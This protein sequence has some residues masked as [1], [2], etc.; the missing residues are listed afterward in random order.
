MKASL[1]N[2]RQSPRKVRLV[3]KSVKG[4]KVAEALAILNFMPKRAAEPLMKLISSAVANSGLKI[5]DLIVKNIEVNKG[6]VLK[7]MMPRARG[8]GFGINKRTSHV[9]VTLESKNKPAEVKA[10]KKAE[11]KPAAAKSSGVAKKVAT[12]KAVK[13]VA[14]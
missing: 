5:E 10:E 9:L 8:S 6:I 13:K 2:Y 14:K 1:K 11:V 4:K 3:A 7:R 12:K